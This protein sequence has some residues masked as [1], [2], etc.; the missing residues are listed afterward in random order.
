MKA[1]LCKGRSALESVYGHDGDNS[2]SRH[3]KLDVVLHDGENNVSLV[4][5]RCESHWCDHY[6][7]EVERLHL[8]SFD[9]VSNRN[10]KLWS[11]YPVGRCRQ[12]ICRCPYTQ[13]DDLSRV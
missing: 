11:V 9:A 6:D 3:D 7:H 1:L 13:R 8:L 10:R 12:R 2:R 4:F 5:D